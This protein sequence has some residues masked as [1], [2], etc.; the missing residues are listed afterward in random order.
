MGLSLRQVSEAEWEAWVARSEHLAQEKRTGAAQDIETDKV[1]PSEKDLIT[2]GQ[3]EQSEA[4][5]EHTSVAEPEGETTAA[6]SDESGEDAA[7]ASDHVEEDMS[8][9]QSI[10]E[11]VSVNKGLGASFAEEG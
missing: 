5:V 2:S 11:P 10:E 6:Q 4:A 9:G 3:G 8:G 7:S 1:E